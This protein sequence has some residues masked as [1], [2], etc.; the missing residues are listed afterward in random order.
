MYADTIPSRPIAAQSPAA[1]RWL[2]SALIWAV[3]FISFR[4]FSSG[5]TA[6]EAVNTGGDI[7]N[8]LGFGAIGGICLYLLHK[9][10]LNGSLSAPLIISWCAAVAV[11]GISILTADYPPGAF[12][13]V[14]FSMIVVLA[15]FTA[16]ALL[17]SRN[18]LASALT[19]AVCLVLAYC[20]LAV[21]FFPQQGV[22]GGGGFE[23]EHAGLWRGVFDHK[24][25][26]SYV[27]GGFVIIS[28]FLV[29]NGKP[30]IGLIAAAL[31]L[32][33]VIESGSKTV[34]GVLPTAIVAAAVTQ[35]ITWPLLRIIVLFLP[36]TALIIATLGAVIYP[37]ILKELWGYVPGLT[38]TGRTDLWIFGLENLMKSP[39]LGYG[40]ESFWA[41]PRVTGLEQPIELAWDV[42]GIVHGHN[43]WLDAMIAFGIP[44]A[45]LIFIVLLVIPVRDYL[46]IP[47]HGNAGR[48]AGLFIGLWVFSVLA[49]NLESFFFRRA[50]P[51]WFLMLMSIVGLRITA[52]MTRPHQLQA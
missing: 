3:V 19:T 2:P 33:F 43:S 27:M 22:H 6:G 34:L 16:M 13:A 4:P 41:T 26:A 11:L 38:Y 47:Q 29:R 9:Q 18:D 12:R 5:A 10:R 30:V 50:D 31:S 45:A 37:P 21:I 40:F 17:R 8:Q 14:A 46:R 52:H 24:N 48:I 44:G 15:A 7:V 23:P 20:Y 32:Y 28:L 42:R 36:I 25:V 35:W 51:V 39:W 49:A 1:W